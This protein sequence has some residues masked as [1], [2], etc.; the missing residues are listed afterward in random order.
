MAT[1]V[2]GSAGGPTVTGILGLA[3]GRPAGTA[4]RAGRLIGAIERATTAFL[5]LQ[6]PDG[7]WLGELEVDITIDAE[8]VMFYHFMGLAEREAE[9]I[10]KALEYIRRRQNPNGSWGLYPGDPGN[11]SATVEAYFAFK[12]GGH[13]PR[14]PHMA[15]AREFVLKQ[16]GVMATR[17]LTKIYLTYFGQFSWSGIPTMP[18]AVVLLPASSRLSIYEFAC[19]ARSYTVPL[20]ILNAKRPHCRVPP[21]AGVDELYT[22]PREQIKSYSFTSD[23]KL[24]SWENLFG[25]ADRVLKL[26]DRCSIRLAQGTSIRRAAAWVLERQTP[27]GAWG[28]IFPAMV[29]SMMALKVLGYSLDDPV[30]ARGL[31]A[32][33]G[34]QIVE[35]DHLRQQPCLSPCWDAA[36][37]AL[38]IEDL[39]RI[40][41]GG[42]R[43][44]A[45]AARERALDWLAPRQILQPGDW[46]VK[47]SGVEPGGWA[48]QFHNEWY[49]DNDDTAVTLMAYHAALSRRRKPEWERA[50]TRGLT[51]LLGLQDDDGGWA[52]FE[53][54]INKEIFNSLPFSDCKNMLDP[55]TPDLA[56]RVLECL[57]RTGHNANFLP[58][59]RCL[60]YIRGS[61]EE[62]GSW[63]GRWGVNYIYGTWSVLLALEQM[64]FPPDD[65]LVRRA[66]DWLES[67]R[68]SDGG[69]G[70]SCASYDGGPPGVGRT[71]ASQTAWAMMGLIAAGRADTEA[72]R[73]GAEYLLETQLADGLWDEEDWTGTGFP[74][75]YYMKYHMFSK[76]FPLLAL[77]RYRRA[78]ER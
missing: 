63:F 19:W 46:S 62:D 7:Y 68:N 59:A 43:E 18:P 31:E 67:V 12:L 13:S 32:L 77:A 21:E 9:S 25:Q 55:S 28:G 49:P 4:P 44:R 60:A 17:M 8:L 39:G 16:G 76:Y 56:G 70:E 24:I 37:G 5:D 57:G 27:D 33:K 2:R 15:R 48:F 72:V 47:A 10:R 14:E 42:L 58:A 34:Y 73:G 30:I 65:P 3:A 75:A 22:V 53:R 54:N 36:W 52:A 51:W 66:A 69:W 78:L 45:E 26:L 23:A 35:S 1:E 50:F 38:L 41:G 11:V 61:Q 71:T 29:N 6:H 64:D 40:L 74:G 20:L